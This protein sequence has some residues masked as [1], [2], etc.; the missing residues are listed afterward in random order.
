MEAT[1]E[2]RTS[3]SPGHTATHQSRACHRRKVNQEI[4]HI[5]LSIADYSD[6]LRQ[7]ISLFEL[8]NSQSIMSNFDPAACVGPGETKH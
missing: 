3:Q 4:E 8:P 5:T 1:V 2:P 6:S 7:T